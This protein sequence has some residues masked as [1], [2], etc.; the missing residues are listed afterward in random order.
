M[1]PEKARCQGHMKKN[2]QGLWSRL[3]ANPIHPHAGQP[4]TILATYPIRDLHEERG[5]PLK[6]KVHECSEKKGLRGKK[7][8]VR[9]GSVQWC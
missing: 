6:K 4:G 9:T 5:E 7:K 8:T 2:R 1:R 3:K